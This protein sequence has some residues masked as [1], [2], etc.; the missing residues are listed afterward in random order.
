QLDARLEA[1]EAERAGPHR[2]LPEAVLTYLLD[3]LLGHDPRGPGGARAV[4]RHE[5][6]PGVLQVKAYAARVHHLHLA[7]TLLQQRRGGSAV[8]VER[9]LHVLRGDRIAV[10]EGDVPAQDELPGAPV[11]RHGPRL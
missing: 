10:V 1:H 6:R 2:R 3:V 4:E 8:A 5:V 9:E 7:H 11:L